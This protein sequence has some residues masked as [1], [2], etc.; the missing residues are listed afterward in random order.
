MADDIASLLFGDLSACLIKHCG[1]EGSA[2]TSE[3]IDLVIIPSLN[4]LIDSCQNELKMDTVM[5]MQT[6]FSDCMIPKADVAVKAMCDELTLLF[7]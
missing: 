3:V 6:S 1:A 4:E 2:E 5:S 7:R